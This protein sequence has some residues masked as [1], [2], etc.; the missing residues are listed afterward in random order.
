[1]A[2]SSYYSTVQKAYIAF[3]GRPADPNGLTYWAARI[4][5]AGG[6]I[7][8]II[9][10]FGTSA[11]ATSLFGGVSNASAVNTLYNQIFG[12]DADIT[13]LNFYVNKLLDG[14]YTLVDV[15]QRIIDGASGADATIVTNKLSAA[16]SFT[17]AIDTAAELIGYSG[18]AS[19][20]T[21]RDWLS[22][23]DSTSASVTA[24]TGTLSAT[25]TSI[26]ETGGVSGN[27]YTLTTGADDV[28]GTSGNDTF[29]AGAGKLSSSDVLDGGAGRDTLSVSLLSET[30]APSL[31]NIEQID[32]SFRNQSALLDLADATGYTAVTVSGTTVGTVSNIA[33]GAKVELSDYDTTVDV[34]ITSDLSQTTA[35]S[36][37]VE[38]SG[39]SSGGV[40]LNDG[41]ETLTLEMTSDYASTGAAVWDLGGVK[42]LNVT[43]AGDLKLDA[44]TAFSAAAGVL[45]TVDASNAGGAVTLVMDGTNW[46]TAM[47]IT[48]SDQADTF[49]FSATLSSLDTVDGGA[50]NDT[51]TAVINA[52][53]TVR[54]TI[55]NVE[56]LTTTFAAAGTV[57][58]RAIDGVTTLNVINSAAAATFTRLSDVT[59]INFKGADTTGDD[60]SVTY[61]TGTD[62]DVTVNLGRDLTTATEASFTFGDLT[63]AGNG[64]SLTVNAIGSAALT[65]GDVS[66]FNGASDLTIN[67]TTV[68]LTMSALNATAAASFDFNAT[69]AATVGAI[70]VSK[71]T[72]IDITATGTAATVGLGA[73]TGSKADSVSVSVSGTDGDDVTIGGLTLQGS[74]I[75]T[76]AL[77]S[78]STASDINLGTVAIAGGTAVSLD[79]TGAVASGAVLSAIFSFASAATPTAS[80]LD[81]SATFT[82]EGQIDIEVVESAN[83]TTPIGDLVLDASGVTSAGKLSAAD[84]SLFGT[85]ASTMDIT[86]SFGAD[87]ITMTNAGSMNTVHG[88]NGADT[89]T[90]GS[91]EDEIYGEA[92]A[93]SIS[94]GAGDD[95]IDGGAGDDTLVGGA[96]NDTILGG[97]GANVFK[98]NTG[99]EGTDTFELLAS[100]ASTAADTFV[101]ASGGA[102]GVLGV[103]TVLGARSGDKFQFA[104]F[105][106]NL[107][108]TQFASGAAGLATG[109]V[110]YGSGFRSAAFGSVTSAN[111]GEIAI[112][113]N[114]ADTVIEVV[115]SSAVG[116]SAIQTFVLDSVA[117]NSTVSAQ[118]RIDINADSGL[119]ITLL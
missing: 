26:V 4:D 81:V 12:R 97:A 75:S 91:A 118:F 6:N 60:A 46:S 17:D 3:Y 52:T 49:A 20:Q 53:S 106:A 25:L 88:G 101:F 38:I 98:L 10:A 72:V 76:I 66:T 100:T 116:V 61:A 74:A 115:V 89:I 117:L 96:G 15:A 24:A 31:R 27:T 102:A 43:G 73:I 69:K 77:S 48:G 94:G 108:G 83:G 87:T 62:L 18:D 22:T 59:T 56:T 7:S 71:A 1:M 105:T 39:T 11:E 82:G 114:G 8:S 57:D 42:T 50:G 80:L 85:T 111:Q 103:D 104:G 51:V 21:A 90:G 99:A 40:D 47:N 37:T 65:V 64:G 14:T 78:T 86:G 95:Y 110:T 29:T 68:G 5:A 63:V 109:K 84:L 34:N 67:A 36:I 16:Q 54:P 107:T 28:T 41:F 55:S 32:V 23:V 33:D 112:Y 30:A 58:A 35:N 44:S 2:A 92:D 79:I 93:D 13:G 19:A 70:D 9:Q 113:S 45:A 119:M